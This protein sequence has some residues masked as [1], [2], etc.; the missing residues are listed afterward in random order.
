MGPA[1]RDAIRTG[2]HM[3]GVHQRRGRADLVRRCSQRSLVMQMILVNIVRWLMIIAAIVLSPFYALW[4]GGGWICDRMDA[5][6]RTI[7]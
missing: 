1:A 7:N 3:D 2:L 6:S 5:K 4:V